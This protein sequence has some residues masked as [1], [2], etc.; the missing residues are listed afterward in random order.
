MKF[1]IIFVFFL[2]IK[3]ILNAQEPQQLFVQGNKLYEEQKYE[4]AIENYERIIQEFKINDANLYY[5]LANCYYRINKLGKAILNYECALRLKPR[6]EDIIYNLNFLRT[7]IN[8]VPETNIFYNVFNIFTAKELSIISTVLY[9]LFILGL[10][11]IIQIKN[12]N[13]YILKLTV[14][15]L[16]FLVLFFGVWT[17]SKIKND[18]KKIGIVIQAPC[19]VYNG[20]GEDYS[21]GFSLNEGKK[22]IILGEKDN[23]YAIGLPKEK[24]KGWAKKDFIEKI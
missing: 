14:Y 17:V 15:I 11:L 22:I 24:L 12:K 13:I 21:I 1:L 20:P 5:N 4:Q 7:L 19:D 10:I 18:T 6:D 9:I 23:W 3:F 2:N 16:L 8:D